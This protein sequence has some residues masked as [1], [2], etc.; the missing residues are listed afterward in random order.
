MINGISNI[1]NK[2]PK[3]IQNPIKKPPHHNQEILEENELSE[4]LNISKIKDGFYIGDKT[5]ATN[6]DVLIQFKISHFVNAAGNQIIN[7][8]QSIG[9]NYLTLNWSENANQKLFDPKD[10]I[11]DRIVKFIDSSFQN[12]EGVLAHSLKGQNRVCLVVL[13]YLMKKYHWSL[14]K[15]MDYL[16]SKKQDVEILPN[17]LEQIKSFEKRLI[18]KG[19]ITNDIPWDYKGNNISN[20]EKL[21]NNTYINGIP[22][23]KLDDIPKIPNEKMKHII[24]IDDPYHKGNLEIIDDEHDLFSKKEIKEITSHLEIKPLKGCIKKYKIKKSKKYDINNFMFNNI[25]ENKIIGIINQGKYNNPG[26]NF[27]SNYSI[28]NTSSTNNTNNTSI[29]KKVNINLHENK[30]L[31]SDLSNMPNYEIEDKMVGTNKS[32][33]TKNKNNFKIDNKKNIKSYI[34]ILSNSYSTNNMNNKYINQQIQPR[35]LKEN[36]TEIIKS[37]NH[38]FN[39]GN[40]NMNNKNKLLNN[41]NPNLI[42]SKVASQ[43]NKTI[44]KNNRSIK[45]KKG[46]NYRN[47]TIEN[48]KN[49]NT[50][51]NKKPSA[52]NLN[53]C[54]KKGI[55]HYKRNNSKI[56]IN[57]FEAELKSGILK[58]SST[59][60]ASAL[61]NK[62]KNNQRP[63]TAIHEDKTKNLPININ[64]N[65]L[66]KENL[67][68]CNQNTCCSKVKYN[69]KIN[70]NRKSIKNLKCNQNNNNNNKIELKLSKKIDSSQHYSKNINGLSDNIFIKVKQGKSSF[71]MRTINN[72]TKNKKFIEENRIN[73]SKSANSIFK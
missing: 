68:K 33:N 43:T 31:V 37:N 15:S 44:N 60:T 70:Y 45:I 16:N 40:N 67:Y 49:L 38:Q 2:S 27:I 52:P 69:N 53:N 63:S 10:E 47:N 6:I 28:S 19:E 32:I 9:L 4:I 58:R 36:S 59:P 3:Q 8:W 51:L 50:C 41:L 39:S 54:G 7:Q 5:A 14:N 22:T 11:A 1:N 23:K 29:S 13:I 62:N 24:W 73:N 34:N 21:L 46:N 25:N 35:L 61:K 42:K 12:G 66:K 56:N 30:I 18:Q 48:N 20:E 26:K 71:M 55:I 64:N 72:K 57:P 17:F 65:I